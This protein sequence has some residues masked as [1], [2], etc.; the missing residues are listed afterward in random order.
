M[1]LR[2]IMSLMESAVGLVLRAVS[3]TRLAGVIRKPA[4]VNFL[5]T[6]EE[7]CNIQDYSI[8]LQIICNKLNVIC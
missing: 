4:I 6:V 1:S 7:I 2:A 3:N 8:L 5:V